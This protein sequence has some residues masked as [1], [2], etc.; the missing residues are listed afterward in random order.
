MY[1]YAWFCFNGLAIN[2]DNSEAISGS[3]ERYLAF[4]LLSI[5]SI[6]GT[7]VPHADTVKTLEVTL[8][9]ELTFWLLNY[10]G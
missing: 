6:A 3:C 7:V 9:S 5:I 1:M 2:P 4:P 10:C 8:D